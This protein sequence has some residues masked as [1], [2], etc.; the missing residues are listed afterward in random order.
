MLYLRLHLLGVDR[1]ELLDGLRSVLR[2]VETVRTPE[3][4][5]MSSLGGYPHFLLDVVGTEEEDLQ[6]LAEIIER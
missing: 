4:Y 2:E 5:C 1:D 6:V 3:S